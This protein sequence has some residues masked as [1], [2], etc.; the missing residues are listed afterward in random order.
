MVSARGMQFTIE[1]APPM[2]LNTL[3]A[4]LAVIEH[5]GQGRCRLLVDSMHFFRSGG[6]LEELEA[7]DPGLIGY[8]Q[9]SD[10]PLDAPAEGYMHESMF[11]RKLPGQGEL[12]LREWV[13]C[14]PIDCEIGIE[15]PQLARLQAGASA[16]DHAAEAVAAARLIG[17]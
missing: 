13:A 16:R 15:T 3:Q 11:A 7:L 10:A 1:F 2:V 5:V 9:L 4:A 14:L 12:R 17:A 8:A 6:Q